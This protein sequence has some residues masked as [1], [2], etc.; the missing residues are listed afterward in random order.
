MSG[1][2]AR[3]AVSSLDRTVKCPGSV[4]LIENYGGQE[5][6]PES[7]EGDAAHWVA[8]QYQ[9]GSPLA[10][11]SVTPQGIA[12]DEDMVEGAQLWVATV[13]VGGV[14][15]TPVPVSRVHPTD[16][17]GTPDFW[18]HDGHLLEVADY[19][20]GHL[21]VEPFENYQLMGYAAGVLNLLNLHDL[22]ILLKLTIVQPRSYTKEGPVRSWTVN[23]AEIRQYINIARMAAIEALSDT[24]RYATGPHC[25]Y[26][27][28][29][30]SCRTLQ[31][32]TQAA[33]D[34]AGFGS[35]L[36]LPPDALGAEMR[37]V[38]DALG[39][40]TAR[41]TGL[42]AQAEALLRKGE[43]VPGYAL[44]AAAGALAWSVPTAEVLALGSA[45]GVELA[46]PTAAITP[47]Q[48]KK[49]IDPTVVEGYSVR[50]P[51]GMKLVKDSTVNSRK[52]FAK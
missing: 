13:G 21:T 18:R 15:E 20:Y 11:G 19:K 49:K 47:T 29:R 36:N 34:F 46:K 16:C 7:L 17:W 31:L 26:C 1:L 39:L 2:H 14:Q 24:P 33:A 50:T 42:D 4:Q 51:G 40:L 38:N 10:V 35:G 41:K 25:L 37:I 12:V 27:G 32:N 48:A 5:A 28:A 22:S 43:R 6:T 3:I 23:A 52:V 8:L 45:F 30:Q 44:E 9:L